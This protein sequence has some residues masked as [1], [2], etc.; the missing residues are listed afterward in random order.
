MRAPRRIVMVLVLCWVS[1]SIWAQSDP[2]T[3]LSSQLSI[4]RNPITHKND[5]IWTDLK[6][7]KNFW[8]IFGAIVGVVVVV[9]LVIFWCRVTRYIQKSGYNVRK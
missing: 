7:P 1:Q 5:T 2:S 4:N 9:C 8:Y 3:R 6:E